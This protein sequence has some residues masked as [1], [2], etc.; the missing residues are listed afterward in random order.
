MKNKSFIFL[1][2]LFLIILIT[3]CSGGGNSGESDKGEDNNLP[4]LPIKVASFF[5]LPPTQSLKIGETLSIDIMLD[6]DLKPVTAISALL[7]YD[8]LLLEL[9]SI[10]T[11]DS[12]F[13]IAVENIV[14]NGEIKI[15][16][17][18]PTPGIDDTSALI[19][20]LNFHTRN[21]GKAQISFDITNDKNSLS[22]AIKDDGEGTNIL[23]H[24][25][26]STYTIIP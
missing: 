25:L 14:Q 17:G 23:T 2:I 5:L 8:N 6:T 21:A 13:P 19:A 11:A 12:D 18:K 9:Y 26:N 22:K 24:A 16:R 1:F 10:E 15:V 7:I 20:T 3:N 4:T